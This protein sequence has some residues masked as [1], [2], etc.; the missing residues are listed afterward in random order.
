MDT[1]HFEIRKNQRCIPDIII[2]LLFGF[3]VSSNSGKDAEIISFS[4][5]SLKTLK[6]YFGKQ[7]YKHLQEYRDCYI[8]AS[9]GK[10]ITTGRRYKHIKR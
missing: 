9:N 1:I 3:G 6:K 2:D 4:K 7:L 8:V 5:K 10:V